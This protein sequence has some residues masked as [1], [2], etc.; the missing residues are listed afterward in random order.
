MGKSVFQNV[1][2][3]TSDGKTKILVTHALHFLSQVDYIYTIMDGKIKERGTY[4]QLMDNQGDFCRF[5]AEFG[6]S[7][8][9]EEEGDTSVQNKVE[10][11]TNAKIKQAVAGKSIMQEEERRT[12][13]VTGDVYKEYLKAGR[14]RLIVP[15]LIVGM[16]MLQGCQVM[17][18][19]W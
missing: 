19:Y 14:G 17:G 11:V 18:S 12:G 2:R 5:I 15:L 3:N 6:T 13:A 10:Q 16:A 9:E 1:F 4:A 8:H 7:E